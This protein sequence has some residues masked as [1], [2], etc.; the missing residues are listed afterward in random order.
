MVRPEKSNSAVEYYTDE[1]TQK[2][3]R[4]NHI[5][6]IQMEMA[7]RAMEIIEMKDGWVLDIGCGSGHSLSAIQKYVEENETKNT[8]VGLD[9]NQNMLR[10]CDN[11][12]VSLICDDMG[13]G[14]PFFPG[15]FDYIISISC[16]QWLFYPIDKEK[17][18]SRIKSFF[19][20]LYY[21][22]KRDASACFQLYFEA[23]WQAQLLIQIVK[24]TGF[25]G[26]LIRDGEGKKQKHFLIIDLKRKNRK[27][28]FI[29][30]EFLKKNKKKKSVEIESD[31]SEIFSDKPKKRLKKDPH[32]RNKKERRRR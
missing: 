22:M 18:E 5:R 31:S 8:I 32:T 27:I 6:K 28:H 3:T 29:T 21:V 12:G 9:L 26:G 30:D 19:S 16:L 24:R 11:E 10:L 1:E 2:Y 23:K 17:V 14:L 20:S 4:N 13:K 15:S 7:W 25:I